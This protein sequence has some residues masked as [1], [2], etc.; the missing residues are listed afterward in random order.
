MARLYSLTNSAGGSPYITSATYGAGGE[1]LSL[2]GTVNEN[3]TYNARLQL[4]RVSADK[5][6]VF[7]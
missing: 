1:L 4:T 2:A 5:A 7:L 3:R 6:T